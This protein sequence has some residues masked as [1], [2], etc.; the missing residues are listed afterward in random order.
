MEQSKWKVFQ[1]HLMTGISYMIPII[2]SAGIVLGIGIMAG[3]LMDFDP[4]SKEIL[5]NGSKHQQF[6]AWLTQVAGAGMMGL[7]FPVFAAFVAYS[8][9]DKLGLA[10][11]FI[12]GLLAAEMGSG[13][14]GAIVIG[15]CA[16]YTVKFLNDRLKFKR[17]FRPVK[18]MFIVPVFSSLFVIIVSYYIVGPAGLL[19]I[20]GITSI[21]TAIGNTGE[22]ALAAVIGGSM[23]FDLGGP[24][25]KTAL[26]I[27]MQLNTD[28]GANTWVPAMI[29]AVIPPIG[30][31][32]AT[33]IDKFVVKKAVF[34]S[35][36]KADG[37]PCFMLGFMGISE[38]AIP[39]AIRDP[40]F[41][42][43]LNVVSSASGAAIAA[44]LGT[45]AVTG[46][47]AA[48]WGWPLA[49]NPIGWA[50]AVLVGSLMV[51]FGAIFRANHLMK[52][53]KIQGELENNIEAV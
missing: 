27:S 8:I 52:K 11:G 37:I 20:S 1:Q 30:I 53:P 40:L 10:P 48:I 25:N 38:G 32:L 39:F 23:A 43:P 31:G 7:M 22:I 34:D 26:A 13:F 2:V 9:A 24:I 12:G 50:L 21:I 16:G 18:T 33:I 6:F 36:L 47:P 19:A 41:M 45:S 51:C 17:T 28:T 29:G 4:W 5:E 44:W 46:V 49:T 35:H 3:Q 14:L 15:I 42:I